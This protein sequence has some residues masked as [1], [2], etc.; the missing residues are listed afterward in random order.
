MKYI[1]VILSAFISC[2]LYAQETTGSVFSSVSKEDHSFRNNYVI[3]MGMDY[4]RYAYPKAWH[5]NT[6]LDRLNGYPDGDYLAPNG[7][8]LSCSYKNEY[9]L[10]LSYDYLYQEAPYFNWQNTSPNS[11]YSRAAHFVDLTAGYNLLHKVSSKF[12]AWGYAGVGIAF[13]ATQ[14]RATFDAGASKYGNLVLGT[15][16]QNI[17]SP[18]AQVLLKYDISHTLFA[19]VGATY[20]YVYSDF[21]PVSANISIGLQFSKV[22]THPVYKNHS[23]SLGVDWVT[24]TYPDIWQNNS[25]I[26]KQGYNID[27]KLRCL[28]DLWLS[29]AYQNKISF[30]WCE[31]QIYQVAGYVPYK[32]T[33]DRFLSER[34][35]MISDYTIGYNFM[36]KHSRLSAWLYGGISRI[37]EIAE[38]R[39]SY[40]PPSAWSEIGPDETVHQD[41]YKPVVQVLIKYSVLKHLFT[42]VGATYHYVLTD[43]QPVTFNVG[44]GYQF[45]VFN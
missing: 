9:S 20:H 17:V 32:E 39:S 14:T 33:P 38:Y 31:S 5:N 13:D 4:A 15:T 26:I 7:A 21:Q 16:K 19:S 22:A 8:W 37:T 28:T 2:G 1:I 36:D 12:S 27:S 43:F 30:K 6:Q 29:Y 35:A 42:S 3:S 18:T 24:A 23:I 11:L 40:I 44:I 45:G 10:R 41:E 25:H 34:Q